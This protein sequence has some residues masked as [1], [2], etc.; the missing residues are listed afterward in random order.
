MKSDISNWELWKLFFPLCQSGG[1]NKPA[2]PLPGLTFPIFLLLLLK[3]PG[4]STR[5]NWK[6]NYPFEGMVDF[7]SDSYH[8]IGVKDFWRS[9]TYV[10]CQEKWVIF[11]LYTC[12]SEVM[13]RLEFTLLCFVSTAVAFFFF[14]LA[15]VSWDGRIWMKKLLSAVEQES[16]I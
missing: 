4:K 1:K 3:Q 15:V 12:K 16:T 8:A 11:T 9:L 5:G 7:T 13:C 14:F 6:G 2:V 10:C